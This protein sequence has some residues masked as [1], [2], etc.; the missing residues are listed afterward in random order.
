MKVGAVV[1]VRLSSSRLPRK[2]LLDVA[3]RT[4]L[5]RV[6]D[7]ARAC[8]GVEVVVVATTTDAADDPLAEHAAACGLAVHRGPVR[9]VLR[10]LAEAA[11]AHALDVVVEVDGDDLLCATEYMARGVEHLLATGADFVS[12]A[13]LP[14]G[15]TPNV[16]RGAAL[17]EAV[18]RKRYDDTETGIFRFLLESGR[19]RV[20]KPAATDPRHVHETVRMTLDYP[21]DL[22]FFRAVHERLDAQ[23]GW[24][25]ADLVALL[26]AEPAL[27]ALN[28]GLEDAYAAHFRAGLADM[29]GPR[30]GD[31]SA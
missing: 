14:L 13:G 31:T 28:A 6:T 4:A 21:Q 27:V 24:T 23:P 26:R 7:R 1:P 2:P 22:A 11:A 25:F 8:P 9:D 29:D 20:E 3:G 12:F 18:R 5:Q 19:F 30:E 10:R 16:V 17:A 15:A